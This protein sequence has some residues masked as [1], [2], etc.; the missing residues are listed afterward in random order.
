LLG[1]ER[2][3]YL[4][5]KGGEGGEGSRVRYLA[6]LE[7]GRGEQTKATWLYGQLEEKL[8]NLHE[9]IPLA[10]VQLVAGPVGLE[11]L[12]SL[13]QRL[14]YLAYPLGTRSKLHTLMIAKQ[15]I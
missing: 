12:L 4:A 11:R 3:Q 9:D 10:G 2:N 15:E 1:K 14:V 8:K 5:I 6:Q 7:G 13:L